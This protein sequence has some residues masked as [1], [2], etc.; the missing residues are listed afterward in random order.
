MMNK[1]KLLLNALFLLVLVGCNKKSGLEGQLV[2][3]TDRP[4]WDAGLMPYGMVYVPSGTFHT[5][6]SDQDIVYSLQATNK[7]ISIVGF[8]MDETEITNNEYRQFTDWVRDSIAHKLIGGE[9]LISSE[10]GGGEQRINWDYPIDWSADGEDA[11]QVEELFYTPENRLY[12]R[13]ELDPNKLSYEYTWVKWREMAK[14]ENKGKPRSSFIERKTVNIWPDEQAWIRDFSYSYNEPMTRTY[15]THPAYDDY[16]V[17]GVTWEQ[18]NA[19]AYW[20]TSLWTVFKEKQGEAFPEEFRLPF[21]HEWE[22]AARGGKQLSPYPWGGPYIR[23]TKGCLL[24]NFKPGRGS[25]ADDGGIYTVNAKSY[26]PNDYGL[27]NM[28]GNVAE[29]TLSSFSE[30]SYAFMHDMNPDIRYDAKE[31]DPSSLKRK[32]VRG[33]SWKDIA[34]FLQTSTRSWEYQDSSKSFIGFRNVMPFMGRSINDFK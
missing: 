24:A 26:W 29:W 11:K 14:A 6:P 18:A 22:Y 28:A 17:V 19:F 32:V 12:G 13:R 16:P 9:H 34:Y 8:F 1:S 25:Y 31:G 33:G 21:E 10:D 23:N 5:G 15:Y 20:R 2:G 27:Y 3:A 4:K 7:Q 30:N